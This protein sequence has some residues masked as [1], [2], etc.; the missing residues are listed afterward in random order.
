M[1]PV[2]W[3]I[4]LLA[5]KQAFNGFK[6]LVFNLDFSVHNAFFELQWKNV[7]PHKI[8]MVGAVP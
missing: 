4:C 5:L 7:I 2:M 8:S 6:C 3:A 1:I